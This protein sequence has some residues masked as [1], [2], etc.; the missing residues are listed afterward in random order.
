MQSSRPTPD[1]LWKKF[2][3][4]P[5]RAFAIV[6]ALLLVLLAIAP[7]KNYFSEWRHY[8]NGYLRLI[9]T[10]GEAITLQRHFQPGIQQKHPGIS[11]D[12]KR[13]CTTSRPW[14]PACWCQG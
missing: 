10:R 7:A 2:F 11:S 8:Q 9:R 14:W 12:C 3:G 5:I 1:S 4:E 13:C 6:S